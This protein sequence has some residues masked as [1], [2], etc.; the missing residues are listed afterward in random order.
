MEIYKYQK[1]IDII[2]NDIRYSRSLNKNP[3]Q[4]AV[5][6]LINNPDKII[7]S[8]FSL[9]PNPAAVDFLINNPDK[10]IWPWFSEN[11]A[12]V[13]FLIKNPDKIDLYYFSCNP[14]PAAVDF[15][16]KNYYD[17]INWPQFSYNTNDKAVDLLI[18][19][20]DKILWYNFSSNSNSRAI[21]FLINQKNA[22]NFIHWYPLILNTNTLSFNLAIKNHAV[23]LQY[24]ARNPRLFDLDYPKMSLERLRVYE[25]ELCHKA[26]LDPRRV[27]VWLD[28]FLERGGELTDFKYEPYSVSNF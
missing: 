10:I 1:Y 26:V 11:P 16:I 20:P 24:V 6:F 17:K 5:D 8:Y 3:H 12:A 2:K 9:N 21:E 28:D 7:W 23:D 14:N 18:K 19:N 15:L 22:S 27:K 4:L 13:N 25:E